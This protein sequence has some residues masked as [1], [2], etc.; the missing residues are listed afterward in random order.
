MGLAKNLED[1]GAGYSYPWV[2]KEEAGCPEANNS[3]GTPV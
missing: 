1:K 3:I 2:F